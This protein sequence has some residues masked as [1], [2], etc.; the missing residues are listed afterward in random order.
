MYICDVQKTLLKLLDIAAADKE[1]ALSVYAT[2]RYLISWLERVAHDE[3]AKNSTGIWEKLRDAHNGFLY[4]CGL[5]PEEERNS[6]PVHYA[7]QGIS[8]LSRT[9]LIGSVPGLMEKNI[10]EYG[11]AIGRAES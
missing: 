9:T 1:K 4:C 8:L 2:A 6:D 3:N 10:T 11:M 7:R 5:L